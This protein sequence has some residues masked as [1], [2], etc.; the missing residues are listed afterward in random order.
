MALGQSSTHQNRNGEALRLHHKGFQPLIKAQFQPALDKFQQALAIRKAIVERTGKG[1]TLNDIRGGYFHL[2][3]Y[4]KVPEYYNQVL[5]LRKAVSDHYIYPGQYVKEIEFL[6]ATSGYQ[7]VDRYGESTQTLAQNANPRKAEA[8]RLLDQGGQ[9]TNSSQFQEALQSWEQALEI[10]REIKDR[11][12]EASSLMIVGNAYRR[13][14][15]YSRAIEYYQQS[16]AIYRTIVVEDR[17]NAHNG[18]AVALGNLGNTYKSLRQYAKA[19]EYYQQSLAIQKDIGNHRGEVVSLYNLGNTYEALGQDTEAI[20]YYQQSLEIYKVIGD[21]SGGAATFF[22]LGNAYISLGQYTKAIEYLQQS[23]A[24]SKEIGYLRGEGSALT[25]LGT[26]YTFLGQYAKAI[27][28]HQQALAIYKEI[29]DG[30]GQG[31][32]LTNL[33]STYLNLGLYTKAIEYYQQSLEILKQI[34]D[35]MKGAE[36]LRGLGSVYMNLGQHSKAIEYYQ[37]AFSIYKDIGDREGEGSSLGNLGIIYDKLGQYTK[38]IEYYQQALSI[39]RNLSNRRWEALSLTNLGLAYKNLGLYPEAEQN[40]L[41]A[42]EVLETLR[43][44]LPDI[45]KVSIFEIQRWSYHLL[46]HSLIAQNKETAA[47]EISERGRARAFVELLASKA[48]DKPLTKIKPLTLK[49]IQQVALE[50]KATLIEYSLINL[51]NNDKIL[52]DL[53]YIWV[54][55]PSGE[56][57]FK[58]FDLKSLNSPL[59]KYVENSRESIGV[60]GRAGFKV[61]FLPSANQTENLTKLHQILIQPIAEFLPTNPEERVIFIP[62]EELFSVPFAALKDLSG[63]YL[64]EKHT[65]LTAPAI[66]VLQLTRQQRQKIGGQGLYSKQESQRKD[67]LIVGNPTMPKIITQVGKAP[68]QLTPLPGAE[69]EAKKIAQMFK[70]NPLLGNEATKALVLNQLKTARFVHLAT[71]GLLDD[72]EGLGVP[73]AV[74]LAPS[75]SDNGL[76][77]ASEILDLKINPELMVLSACDTGQGKITGDGVIGLSRSLITAGVPSLIVSL[78]SVPDAPTADLMV[79]FYRQLQ[80]GKDKAQALRQAMLKTKQTHPNPRDWAAFTLIGE[81]E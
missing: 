73:G 35:P 67:M 69:I 1:K 42:I 66:Q 80:Q 71:H 72:F 4:L 81:A 43:Q 23:L 62:H 16:L 28:L 17:K 58:S 53:V 15:Q 33:G 55:K 44:N 14:K 38:A 13:L 59:A 18:E 74:A 41:A 21:R 63:K 65:I 10:Y 54:V 8:D 45:D 5:P 32:A 68:E 37:Q 64:V 12:G 60:R 77:T 49:E 26:T 30:G 2:G 11:N 39:H 9:Q 75:E 20:E 40:L 78:W 51:K 50:Q 57:I 52:Y 34:G 31:S 61:V 27:V 6:S 22:R 24:I 47:L 56:V 36:P 3:Q 70:T 48:S 46:Q 29:G 79:E 7:K 19:I 76:L 25:A